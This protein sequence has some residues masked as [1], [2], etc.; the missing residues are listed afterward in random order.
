MTREVSSQSGAGCGNGTNWLVLPCQTLPAAARVAAGGTG[1][2]GGKQQFADAG[3]QPHAA[4]GGDAASPLV[5]IRAP[6]SDDNER[7]GSIQAFGV[8]YRTHYPLDQAEVIVCVDSDLLC[9]H[10]NG[11]LY[12]LRVLRKGVTPTA[13]R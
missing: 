9:T 8:P 6:F 13:G 10:P 2:V 5:R 4:A 3:R 7:E 12:V 11:V 1:R